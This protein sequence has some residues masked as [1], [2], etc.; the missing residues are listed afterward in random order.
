LNGNQGKFLLKRAME[1][2]LP[3]EIIY[4]K[5]RGFP[6]PVARWFREDLYERTA[7]ILLDRRAADRRYYRP[8]YVE[9]VLQRHRDGHE[10]LSRRIFSLLTL[11]MWHQKYV[12]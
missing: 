1:G 7:S 4:R 10:D 3:H 12:D 8:G 6:V 2:M 9:G 5:K 11:E